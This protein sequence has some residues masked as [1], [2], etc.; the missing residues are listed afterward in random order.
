[1]LDKLG[2]VFAPRPATATHGLRE[3][4]PLL[5]VLRNRLGY[6]LNSREVTSILKERHVKID[7]KVRTT[8]KFPA[9]FMDVVTIQATGDRFRLLYDTKGR[10]VLHRI[11]EKEAEYKLCKVAKVETQKYG[12][13]T[14]QTHD[15]RTIRYPLPGTGLNDTV[16]VNLETGNVKQ[17]VKFELGNICMI[18]GGRNTGRIGEIINREAHPGAYEIVHVRD[19]A[20][21]TFSTRKN[22]VFVLGEGHTSLVTLPKGKGVKLS[23]IEDRK[24]KLQKAKR[25]KRRSRKNRA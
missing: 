19:M 21:H 8:S 17:V 3:S 1:M 4:I 23:P 14:I 13:P 22:N 12:V 24:R 5:L 25:A 16:K 6:A 2:G 20:G 7:G 10:F 11:G 15:G 18:T 9:G